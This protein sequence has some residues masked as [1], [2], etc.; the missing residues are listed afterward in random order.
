MDDELWAL[1]FAPLGMCVLNAEFVVL[2]WNRALEEWTGI[3]RT[4]IVGSRIDRFF[5]KFSGA[6]FRARLSPVFAGGPPIVLS[7]QL[8]GNLIPALLPNGQARVEK[9]TVNA[10]PSLHDRS[11][12]A[13][14]VVEDV[15]E[16]V[17][18]VY[19][20]RGMRDK[21][22]AEAQERLAAQKALAER[23][24]MYR[25][26]LET[27]PTATLV[28]DAAGKIVFVN[29]QALNTF[30]AVGTEQFTG[31]QVNDL[32]LPD[33]RSHGLDLFRFVM[34]E[35][36]VR[37]VQLML[38]RFD[39]DTFVAEINAKR[40]DN[41]EGAPAFVIFVLTDISERLN[42]QV[43]LAKYAEEMHALYAT[44]LEINSHVE[45]NALLQAIVQRAI[46]LLDVPLGSLYLNTEL[47][48]EFERVV[49]FPPDN[50][51]LTIRKGEG[52]AGRVIAANAPQV[53]E[54]YERWFGKLEA[55]SATYQN[56]IRRVLGVPLRVRHT[57]IGALT[58]ADQRVGSFSSENVRLLTLFAD[59]AALAIENARLYQQVR[60]LAVTDPLTH[61]HNRRGFF[62]LAE[63]ELERSRRAL[64]PLTLVTF[65]IDHFKR[66]NDT[67]G[68]A[69]GDVVLQAIADHSRNTLRSVDIVGRIGGEEFV[70]LLTDT[71]VD[72]ALTVA[73]RLRQ[74]LA[75][76]TI[77]IPL[78][79]GQSATISVTISAG[80]AQFDT[81]SPTINALMEHADKALYQAKA[82]G[83][84]RTVVWQ[85]QHVNVLGAFG[86]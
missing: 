37:D 86:L 46:T 40:I 45:L 23:E 11:F 62:Q 43:A 32:V 3:D 85:K 24:A 9:I 15:T 78:A 79:D 7:P 19:E 69:A 54:D 77:P 55:V 53:I 38:R 44:A 42:A 2:F 4:Q 20:F 8:H 83:R 35:N 51:K 25:S 34:E 48:D 81:D 68:H 30:G 17:N 33:E 66:V 82:D 18:R 58:I 56:S 36:A 27:S 80:I 67:Y 75:S 26:L 57:V 22:N 64:T 29:T 10:I 6:A 31:L 60:Q 49:H 65:D 52:L 74:T 63:H 41:P 84:N 12:C 61:L 72:V 50:L 13:L 21:A 28:T 39:N 47:P 71:S 76:Q 70:M 5:S 59:Q 14:V 73:E 16:L 1:D